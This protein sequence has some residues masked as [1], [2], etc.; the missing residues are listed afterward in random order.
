MFGFLCAINYVTFSS[1]PQFYVS[2]TCP[3][4]FT[5]QSRVAHHVRARPRDFS[6]SAHQTLGRHGPS[7][8]SRSGWLEDLAPGQWGG[9]T[10]FRAS[11]RPRSRNSSSP[12]PHS[13]RP[14]VLWFLR[15]STT[16]RPVLT[17]PRSR[18]ALSVR[19][20]SSASCPSTLRPSRRPRPA[21][22]R[23]G[24]RVRR[25]LDCDFM[26]LSLIHI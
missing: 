1:M 25:S 12:S 6:T 9:Q 4:R 18:P 8:Q 11:S 26:P 17:T 10:R 23:L 7:H 16:S 14:P 22:L 20:E 2:L 21:P 5:F 24:V 13:A 19:P 3:L 15:A